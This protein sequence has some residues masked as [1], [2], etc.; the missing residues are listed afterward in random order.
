MREGEET[1]EGHDEGWD[2]A[3]HKTR[4]GEKR[5]RN[6]LGEGDVLQ[7]PDPVA[8]H[9]EDLHQ[10]AAVGIPQH[11]EQHATSQIPQV[12][13]VKVVL[14]AL[15]LLEAHDLHDL[16][17]QVQ[18]P[19]GPD[20]VPGHGDLGQPQPV[21]AL[22]GRRVPPVRP[23]HHEPLRHKQSQAPD[24]EEELEEVNLARARPV[25]VGDG[26]ADD[27]G[28]VEGEVLVHAGR[29]H[30][31]AEEGGVDDVWHMANP[32]VHILPRHAPLPV[33][34]V[35]PLGV[36]EVS[37]VVFPDDVV[38]VEGEQVVVL[39]HQLPE[40]ARQP[41]GREARAQ[42]QRVPTQA[43]ALGLRRDGVDQR[44][45]GARRLTEELCQVFLLEV[46]RQP[47]TAD[48][49]LPRLTDVLQEA[50]D[51]IRVMVDEDAQRVGRHRR[52]YRELRL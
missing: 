41:A 16:V 37:L 22:P 32:D 14:Q 49:S 51:A 31:G 42:G 33:E 15:D 21:E 29:V 36:G 28:L 48:A 46:R 2:K 5:A 25:G 8:E 24:G 30:E 43:L 12:A 26:P 27:A 47:L 40:P 44:H 35:V 4:D 17:H 18:E 39:V 11:D 10:P 19:F 34:R 13:E 23:H 38:L 9:H 45:G 3:S 6:L 20:E 7:Q 52:R 1:N 50:G